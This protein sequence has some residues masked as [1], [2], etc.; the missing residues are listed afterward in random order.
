MEPA[1]APAIEDA[2]APAPPSGIEFG[3]PGVVARP[4]LFASRWYVLVI[5]TLVFTFQTID[6]NLVAVLAEP[7]KH[8]FQLN[9][10]QL[11][12]MTGV[13]FATSYVIAGIPLGLLIDR[14]NR[15]RLIAGLLAI[16]STLTFFSGLA[17]TYLWL[18]LA[19]M[20]IA[21]AEAGAAPTCMSLISDVFPKQ[22][23]ATAFGLFHA[24]S[25]IG[26]ALGFA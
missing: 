16:W 9:D 18:L 1:K 7:I 6:R 3:A 14:V 24:S 5:L 2:L 22:Q 12:F 23:R 21:A 15:V 10:S 20:G 11:G 13:V 26:F 25:P 17:R 8:Q 4:A 19:R